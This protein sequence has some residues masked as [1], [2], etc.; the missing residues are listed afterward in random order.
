M[1]FHVLDNTHLSCNA[2]VL[3]HRYPTTLLFYILR[4]W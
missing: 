1:T 2:T 3:F 4:D